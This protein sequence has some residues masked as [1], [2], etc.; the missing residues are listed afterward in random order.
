MTRR[1]PSF[2]FVLAVPLA[3]I[4]LV[5][6]AFRSTWVAP[7]QDEAPSELDPNEKAHRLA[8]TP[9]ETARLLARVYGHELP[10]VQ[11]IPAMALVGR[12]ELGE[13]DGDES[14]RRDVE[15][16]VAPYVEGNQ[17]PKADSG[18]ALSGHLIFSELAKRSEG[19]ARD[20]LIALTRLAS[21]QGLDDEGKPRETMPHHLEMSDSV[22]MGAPI[23]AQA[24]SLTG[25]PRYWEAC[26]AHLEFMRKLVLRDDGLYRH[27]PL[28][29]AAWGRG[30]GFPALGVALTLREFPEEHP[31]RA[32]LLNNF[33]AHMRALAK[34]QGE[35]GVWHQVIDHPE[36]YPELSC[37]SM[38]AWAMSQGIRHN[39]L[40]REEF[41]PVVRR[42]WD[43]ITVRIADDGNLSGVCTGTGKQLTL[44]DY[45]DRPAIF[46]KDARGGAMA[47]LVCVE[48]SRLFDELNEG[49]NG[50]QESKVPV[51]EIESETETPPKSEAESGCE[52]G[53]VPDSGTETESKSES[54]EEPD[55]SDELPR[56]PPKSPEDSLRAIQ[57]RDGFQMELVASEPL[58]RSP[59]AMSFDEYGRAYIVELPE[60]NQYASAEPHGKGAI[61]RLED[62]SGDGKFDRATVFVDELDYPTA[63]ACWKGGVL[64]GVAPDLLYCRDTTGDGKADLR[65]R[66]YTGFG[67]DAAGEGM[68]NSFQWRIDNRFHIPTG[69]NGGEI[70]V[71]EEEDLKRARGSETSTTSSPSSDVKSETS[72]A[73]A[74]HESAP[75]NVRGRHLL[76]EPHRMTIAP[77]SGGGQHGISL[78]DWNLR[79]FVC[80]N[81]EPAHLIMYDGR[82]L[83]RNPYLQARPAAINIA[84]DGKYTKLMRISEVEPW[85]VLRTRLRSEGAI[86]GSDE[87][88]QASGFFTGATGLTV[89][90][91]DAWPAEFRGNLLVG[92][93]ANNLVYRARVE[94]DGVGLTAHRA[95]EEAEFLASSDNWFRPV[96]FA[97]APD[98]TLYVMDM[99]RELIEGAA[100]LAPQI[101]KHMDTRAGFDKGRIYRIAPEGFQYSAP[102]RLGDLSSAELVPFYEHANA[103]HRDTASRLIYERQDPKAL[104]PL[105]KLASESDSPLARTMARYSLQGLGALQPEQVLAAMEDPQPEARI[106][107]MLLAESHT[108][109][110]GIHQA[111]LRLSHDEDVRVRY[112]AAFTL[113]EFIAR[114]RSD[115][116][117]A[118]G[119]AEDFGDTDGSRDAEVSEIS[120][121]SDNL[122]NSDATDR[123]L[124]RLA[125]G[126]GADPWM[127]LAILSSVGQR[128]GPFVARLLSDP[129]QRTLPH[130][131]A[132]A[133]ALA[134][135][136]G[137]ADQQEELELLLKG[138]EQLSEQET[139]KSLSE[140]LIRNM[141]SQQPNL[142][143]VL[144]RSESGKAQ[145]IIT[146]ILSEAR[147]TAGSE[148]QRVPRRVAA[149]QLLS[150]APLETIRDLLAEL[151]ESYQPQPV[152][153][154]ALEALARYRD[155]DVAHLI[156]D[157]WPSQ[158]PQLRATS[159]ETLFARSNWIHQFLDAVEDERVARA[160]VDAARVALLE[161]HEDERI[162]NRAAELLSGSA[163]AGRQDVVD[164]YQGAL[165]LQ[166]DVAR[167]RQ[168]FRRVC[169]ACHQL[170]GY[171]ESIGADL[172][173][174]R[175][176]GLAAVLLNTL[177]PNREVKPQYLNYVVIRDDG[178]TLTGMIAAETANSLTIRKADGTSEDVLRVNIEAIRSTGVSFMPE[179]L[180]RELDVAAM[181]DLLAYLNSIE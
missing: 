111:V 165:E 160:D 65:L 42:A 70:V 173:A 93:V 143:E 158:T 35:D 146:E 140:R 128:R 125:T 44:Q 13:L 154:A 38:I 24:G 33:R 8:R 66:L 147:S 144:G 98:G 92:E 150:T 77:T 104:A 48:L 49:K 79:V 101:L 123:A 115:G 130:I 57:L 121:N 136:I 96:Q 181:A 4:L 116:A 28:C 81:S 131:M 54:K 106:H 71:A 100:F 87:G 178:R 149:I 73:G 102:P 27:S 10:S 52:S 69:L 157:A 82:Y 148:R 91:G 75:I 47:L 9:L 51:F 124:A 164:A 163:L 25:D 60:Y 122:D 113:G 12:L 110:S 114:N 133:E 161:Q 109:H 176:R 119:G 89:Y 46:G 29:E 162:R 14:H 168:Q 2:L 135:Q 40:D 41:E 7:A 90:R 151:L 99:Y 88:G 67:Q 63:V 39:W 64:V 19:D 179:G 153:V 145:R 112:Q 177:D 138:V 86:P 97:N 36:S 95:D 155:P 62:T 78:D 21:D 56:I 156:L 126:D 84:P 132:M 85:R 170:E 6:P 30:N 18:S 23:L 1:S 103:W 139:D 17:V 50:N 83:A 180:E 107:G 129:E 11:Y 43:A 76:L 74:A 117:N 55:Y 171:G 80:G 59:M 167:G 120:D 53:C 175:D 58:I 61:K 152:Q 118:S 22:F 32:T 31:Y 174:I 166:G 94:P 141:V 15:Q 68:L 127:Q 5:S 159:L 105:R 137:A 172:K 16:I 108:D 45:F 72:E 34:H 37:T 134:T 142:R 20:R 3:L 26:R 169:A